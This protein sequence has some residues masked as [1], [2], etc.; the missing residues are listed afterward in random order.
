MIQVQPLFWVASWLVTLFFIQGAALDVEK[1]QNYYFPYLHVI[2]SVPLSL[3]AKSCV[4]LWRDSFLLSEI[5]Q[6]MVAATLFGGSFGYSH[7]NNCWIISFWS[8]G[9]METQTTNA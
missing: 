2:S 9:H 7:H 1:F 6:N 3:P 4:K 8:V 5:I